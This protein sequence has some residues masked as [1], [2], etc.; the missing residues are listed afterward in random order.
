MGL[1]KVC[2]GGV[3][4]V[5]GAVKLYCELEL[6]G[7]STMEV[8]QDWGGEVH[9]KEGVGYKNEMKFYNDIEVPGL[10]PMGLFAV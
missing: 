1:F 9:K 2:E 3:H 8:F 7:Y 6:T 4:K 5:E 10:K